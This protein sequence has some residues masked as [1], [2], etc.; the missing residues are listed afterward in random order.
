MTAV[1]IIVVVV[2]PPASSIVVVAQAVV[3]ALSLLVGLDG[4]PHVAAGPEA[5]PDHRCGGS[6][7][8]PLLSMLRRG[9]IRGMCRRCSSPPTLRALARSRALCLFRRHSL[10]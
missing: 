2:T 3:D 10:E 1:T 5:A 6:E 9:W 4:V 8:F 7:P